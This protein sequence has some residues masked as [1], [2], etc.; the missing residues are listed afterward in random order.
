MK[1]QELAV[2]ASAYIGECRVNR[3]L[4]ENTILAYEQDLMCF[5]KFCAA[6]ADSTELNH[7][8]ILSYLNHLRHVRKLQP[9]T[10]RRRMLT[11]RAFSAWLHRH[12]H[13][14]EY[15]FTDLELE[16]KL[17]KRLPRPIDH[18]TLTRLLSSATDDA[19]PARRG[20]EISPANPRQSTLLA[21]S[22]LIATGVRIGELTHIRINDISDGAGRIRIRGKGDKERTV[23]VGNQTLR[24]TLQDYL[25]QRAKLAVD[26]DFLFLNRNLRRLTEQAF[27]I[28]LRRLS[29]DLGIAPHVTP[30]RFRHSAAT[31][32]IEEGI[33][34]RI[35]QRLLGHASISTTEI[36][37]YVSDA[38]LMAALR[39]ADPLGKLSA[40]F[41]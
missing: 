1:I 29:T 3:A 27:R 18:G 31:L 38:S 20:V 37:T 40:E 36:Y 9:A 5:R 28:R 23:Y 4:S 34:I 2:R 13:I 22:L 39:S 32:L 12:R 6:N 26:N 19:G 10:I 41:T 33:D 25:A 15:A 24:T 17:P 21:M 11:V 7:A 14:R 16:L 30:H 35:V 8:C